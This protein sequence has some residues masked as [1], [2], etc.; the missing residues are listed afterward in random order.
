MRKTIALLFF[1]LTLSM[2]SIPA[3]A[4]TITVLSQ[5]YSISG[6]V[7]TSPLPPAIPNCIGNSQSSSTSPVSYQNNAGPIALDLLA[8]GGTNLSGGFLETHGLVFG[9][10]GSADTTATM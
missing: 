5:T 8:N 4:N 1:A 9:G 7:C 10:N 3:Q 6:G 2:T